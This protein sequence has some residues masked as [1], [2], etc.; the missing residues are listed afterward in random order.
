MTEAPARVCLMHMPANLS[1][2][3]LAVVE[4]NDKLWRDNP[5]L[6]NGLV[7]CSPEVLLGNTTITYVASHNPNLR[8]LVI[9]IQTR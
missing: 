9:R 1:L 4:T 6:V 5:V 7:E 8:L 2:I 3:H